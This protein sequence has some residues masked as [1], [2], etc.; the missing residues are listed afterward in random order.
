MSSNTRT[1]QA[2]LLRLTVFN[3]SDLRKH[4]NDTWDSIERQGTSRSERVSLAT[5][6]T[7]LFEP[8]VD[9]CG[10]SLRLIRNAVDDADADWDAET[11]SEA[12]ARIQ[13]IGRT[14][15]ELRLASA[16]MTTCAWDPPSVSEQK[17]IA[18]KDR[19]ARLFHSLDR[20]RD[21]LRG[22][23]EALIEIAKSAYRESLR[24]DR[25]QSI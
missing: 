20:D 22:A 18:A 2:T 13:C 12:S 10:E 7:D 11:R 21:D 5:A 15:M 19:F 9:E 24:P 17:R 23:A 25:Q 1:L 8:I 4:W 6:F 16:T 3:A 14:L